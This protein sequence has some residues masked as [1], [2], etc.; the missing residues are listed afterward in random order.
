M[1]DQAK[2]KIKAMFLLVVF[3]LNTVAGF[4]CSV[5]IDM[6]YNHDHHHGKKGDPKHFHENGPKHQHMDMLSEAK[7]KSASDD[8]CCSNDVTRFSLLDKSVVDNNLQ[9]EA[10]VF[11]LA[12]TTAFSSPVINESG[13]SVNSTFQF[14]R[15][16]SFLNDTDIQTAIRRFQI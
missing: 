10:P 11:L 13:L 3:S 14:L 6:G 8:D 7:F 1:T 4:A 15:R 5:G 16:S 9:L 12:F 2:N